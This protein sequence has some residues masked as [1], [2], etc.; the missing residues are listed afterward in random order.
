[1]RWVAGDDTPPTL[2]P[3]LR[4]LVVEWRGRLDGLA[5]ELERL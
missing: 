5:R 1:M 4:K 2:W 3:E